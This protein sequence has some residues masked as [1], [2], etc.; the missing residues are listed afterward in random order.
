MN[1]Y[2]RHLGD[3]ARDTNHLSALE[4]GIY[5]LLLDR[6]YGSEAPI[7]A[8][9]AHRIAKASSDSEKDALAYVLNQFFTLTDGSY[10]NRRAD[11]EIQAAQKRIEAARTNGR[12]GGRPQKPEKNPD[13]TQRV[14][15]GFISETQKE[16]SGNPEGTQVKALQS[17]ISN[18]QSPNKP[19]RAKRDVAVAVATVSVGHISGLNPTVWD[20]WVDYRKQIGK[21]IKPVSMESAARELAGY[22]TDQPAVVEQSIAKGWQGLF[23]LQPNAKRPPAAPNPDNPHAHLDMR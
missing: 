3:Y 21:P 11:A 17:P 5:T 14:A 19:T 1:Y 7:P 16:P 10:R 22:G 23:A 13:V 6:Y 20:R 18:H 8:A 12:T 15:G 2:Q 9:D 4:H